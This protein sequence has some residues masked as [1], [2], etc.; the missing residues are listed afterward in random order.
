MIKRKTIQ[1]HLIKAL[2]GKCKTCLTTEKLEIHHII[3]LSKGGEDDLSNIEV[4]CEK[5]HN[6]KHFGNIEPLT[7]KDIDYALEWIKLNPNW[8]KKK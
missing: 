6:E 4:L 3:P 2:G 8:D 1:T 7:Q 5:H